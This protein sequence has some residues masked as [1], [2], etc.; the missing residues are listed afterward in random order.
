MSTLSLGADSGWRRGVAAGAGRGQL[1]GQLPG[2]GA[3]QPDRNNIAKKKSRA[4][5]L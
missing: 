2:Q 5:S 4:R 3:Q 1:P